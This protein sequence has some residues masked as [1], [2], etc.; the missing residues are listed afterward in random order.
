MEAVG[1][2][3]VP[4]EN[5]SEAAVID[6]VNI[7]VDDFVSINMMDKS[8]CLYNDRVSSDVD[9][10]EYEENNFDS[11]SPGEDGVIDAS[12]LRYPYSVISIGDFDIENGYTLY[13][14][15]DAAL[16]KDRTEQQL[17]VLDEQLH[18]LDRKIDGTTIK[19]FIKLP[20]SWGLDL[21]AV[22]FDYSNGDIKIV[23]DT[24]PYKETLEPEV[25]VDMMALDALFNNDKYIIDTQ[26]FIAININNIAAIFG[27]VFVISTFCFSI[28][29]SFIKTKAK[30]SIYIYVAHC[31]YD[32]IIAQKNL[33]RNIC[34]D[35]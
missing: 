19:T 26:V 9:Y 20:G 17:Q 10:S 4:S 31:R 16:S 5:A 21:N 11:I 13:A 32:H 34:G 12:L 24:L 22:R 6:G 1:A 2:I 33:R 8:F 30:C 14:K 15:Y 29:Y 28:F 3:Y 7:D 23:V 27:L 18:V 35:F 25:V